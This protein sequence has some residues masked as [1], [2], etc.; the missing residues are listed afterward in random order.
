MLLEL[1]NPSFVSPVRKGKELIVLY[2]YN[3]YM[4]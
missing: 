2:V 4:Y 1:G 3:F